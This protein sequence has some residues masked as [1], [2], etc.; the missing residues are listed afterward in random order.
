MTRL[1]GHTGLARVVLILGIAMSLATWFF[2]ARLIEKQALADFDT[3]TRETI[4]KIE[5]R[6]Q[7]YIDVL[8]G[9]EGLFGHDPSVSRPGFQ[10]YVNSL[11]L[12]TRYP[13]IQAVEFIRRVKEA[14]KPVYEAM[15]RADRSISPTGYPGF[16]ISPKGERAEYFV[17]HYLEPM[18]GNEAVFGLDIRTRDSARIAAERARDLGEPIATGRYR[19]MQEKQ[20]QFGLVV[21]LPLYEIYREKRTLAQRRAELTGFVNIVFRVDDLFGELID[22]NQRAEAQFFVFDVGDSASPPNAPTRENLFYSSD[23]T[24]DRST[25]VG[26]A[27]DVTHTISVAGRRWLF[28]FTGRDV[29]GPPLLHPLSIFAF[30]SAL[31]ISLLLFV[32]LRTLSRSRSS[33]EQMADSATRE[34]R[35]QLRFSRQ[36]LEMI[37]NPVFL[38]DVEGRFVSCNHAFEEFSSRPRAEFIGKTASQSTTLEAANLHS[39]HDNYL[40]KNKGSRTYELSVT[41]TTDGKQIDAIYN[42]AAF[43]DAQ[44]N[45]TGVVGVIIDI[46]ERKALERTLSESNEKLHSIIEASPLAIVARDL[47]AVITLWN[48][49]A[50]RILGW[51]AEEVLGTTTTISPDD[52]RSEVVAMRRQTQQGLMITLEE[53]RRMRK[54]GVVLDVSLSVAPI[55]NVNRDVVGTMVLFADISRRKRAEAALRESEAQ[56]RLAMEAANM[57]SWY[58]NAGA[59]DVRYSDGF[60]LLFGLPPGASFSGYNQFLKALHPDDRAATEATVQQAMTSEDNF[61]IECRVIWP[62]QSVHWLAV[63]GQATRAPSGRAERVVG[64]ATDITTRKLGEQRIA[65]LAHH[66]ALTGLPNRVLLHDRIR[67]A[68]ALSHRNATRVAVLFM[69]L[70]HFKHINDSLGHHLGDQL[71]QMAAV[72]IQGCLRELDTVSRLGGDE[73]V[74]VIPEIADGSEG[75]DLSSVAVKLL[76]SLASNFRLQ[77][78][79]LHISASIGI[80]IYPN[81]GENAETLMRNAD[82]AMYHAKESGRSQYQFFTGEMNVAARQR[83]SLQTLLRRSLQTDDFSLHYQ[84]LFSAANSRLLGFEALLR[85]RNPEGAT[86]RPAEFISV[87][88]D[89]GLIIPIGEWVMREACRTAARWQKS[90]YALKMS[91]NVS[92]VQLR[93]STFID[94]VKSALAESGADPLQLEIEITERVIV[95]GHAHSISALR[96]IDALGIQIAID[97]FGTGYSGLSYLKQFPIDTVKIDQ[98]FIRDLTV[99]ADDEAIVRAIIAMS[100]SLKLNIVAE[101]VEH[102]EQ[103]SLLSQLGCDMVQ[104]YYF[105]RPLP[106]EE[107]DAFIESMIAN[108]IRLTP[109]AHNSR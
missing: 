98:S 70:D 41:R 93:R 63:K 85:W 100:K 79:D 36:L 81:D 12:A 73:F 29:Y 89:S 39:A 102:V 31:V 46:T 103:L 76:E 106:I 82:T 38:K 18:I 54:D 109:Q 65:F 72:R 19:L 24:E 77:G 47:D 91:V 62:D 26:S 16:S 97:D 101:G 28:K 32:V 60:A 8:Q 17:V 49:A 105:S 13:G 83:L 1:L 6:T 92:A 75:S 99:D 43:V 15:V 52:I 3:K 94:T 37:P 107:A 84:P 45:V 58:W 4:N 30:L 23:Q 66:D 108:H 61:D 59:G 9:L 69:D 50:E 21:Y 53:T 22:S 88:E 2:F 44:G 10:R 7:R 48:P 27:D 64:V 78:H 51:K 90:G 25:M 11:N 57:G 104:G 40:L 56:L 80:S 96:Q 67:Q 42:K 20:S 33:A 34:L 95:G 86:V 74:I 71:L 68:I 55:R 14:D 5:R 87:A 35:D